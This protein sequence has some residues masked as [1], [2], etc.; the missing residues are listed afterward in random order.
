MNVV[1]YG[2]D[3]KKKGI[4]FN[5]QRFS[6]NDGP[7]TR[8]IVLLKGC[9]LVCR[10]CSNPKSENINHE[11]MFNKNNCTNCRRCKN[12]CAVGAID[13]SLPC[14]VNKNKCLGCGKCVD[15]CYSGALV[16]TGKDMTIE[17]VMCALKKE[18]VQYRRSGGGITL[19]GG[20][21]LNQPDFSL[22]ILKASKSCGWYTAIETTAYAS[23]DII[24]K[25]MPWVD[26]VLLDIKTM[27]ENNHIKYTGI[28]NERII[29]N[30]KRIA[31][32]D[33]EVIVR[34][35]VIPKFNSDEK[36]I[37]D[38]ANFTK[39]LKTVK[40]IQLLPYHKLGENKYKCLGRKYDVGEEIR[41]PD[42]KTMCKLKEVVEQ[43]GLK[44][45]IVS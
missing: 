18:S 41:T 32:L 30:I 44:C 14:R 21:A 40:E 19:S 43:C 8:N 23:E 27:D 3:Y 24:E 17:E 28:S 36:S 5:I 38:I 12:I 29:K 22:E 13:F 34:V 6:I 1:N 37:F 15:T 2:V 20:D 35:P 25:V 45:T 39:S 42:E 10:S 31:N 9:S 26:V 33:V 7:G 11:V 4:V 16:M